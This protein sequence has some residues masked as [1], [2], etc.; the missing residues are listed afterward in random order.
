MV[1]VFMAALLAQ[2]QRPVMVVL[3]VFEIGFCL[4]VVPL[5]VRLVRWGLVAQEGLE[6]TS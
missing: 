1:I 3:A 4:V 5:Y 2:D 6:A